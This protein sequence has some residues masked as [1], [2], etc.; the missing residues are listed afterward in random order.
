[1]SQQEPNQDHNLSFDINSVMCP[2]CRKLHTTSASYRISST[3][4]LFDCPSF[5]DENGKYH[6]HDLNK[7]TV[8]YQ[9]S[10]NHTWT[11]DYMGSCWCGWKANSE[12]RDSR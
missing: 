3:V 6:H 7:E 5:Y 12:K 10:N 11:V 4:T 8:T 2:H 1:V 9:C